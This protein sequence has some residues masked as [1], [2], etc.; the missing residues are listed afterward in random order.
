MLDKDGTIKEN[1][2]EMEDATL[3]NIIQTTNNDNMTKTYKPLEEEIHEN[4]YFQEE[5][6]KTNLIFDEKNISPFK[7]YFH[8]SGKYEILLMILGTIFA[9]LAGIAPPFMCYLFGDMAND[10]S[11]VNIEDKQL[12]LFKKLMKCKNVEEA[13]ALSG[14]VKDAAWSFGIIYTFAKEL[15][16]KFDNNVN[17]LVFS[18][19]RSKIFLVLL[20]YETNASFKRKIFRCY[21]KA[22]ARLV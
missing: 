19:W 1:K 12:D 7:L 5:V 10:F 14:N 3:I 11:N 17:K 18:F 15:F 4:S 21:F 22:R 16:R 20:W 2:N 13:K 8:L 6:K 9:F